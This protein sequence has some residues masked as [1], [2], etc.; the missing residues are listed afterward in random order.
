M[1]T[2]IKPQPDKATPRLRC[3][4]DSNM[5]GVIRFSDS[6]DA[7]DGLL[8]GTRTKE[9]C[10]IIN[11]HA[12]LEAVA[13]AASNPAISRKAGEGTARLRQTLANL[14]A[15]RGGKAVQS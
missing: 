14:A 5:P 2:Q 6:A 13:E 12:A 7:F 3:Y 11:E 10:A 9:L 4:V 8:A 1:T 15:V